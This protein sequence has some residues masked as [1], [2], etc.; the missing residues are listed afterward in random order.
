MNVIEVLS[1]NL[2]ES[3]ERDS[4]RWPKV[5]LFLLLD[6]DLGSTIITRKKRQEGKPMKRQKK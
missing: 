6:S 2:I 5:G 3:L 4:S 1:E